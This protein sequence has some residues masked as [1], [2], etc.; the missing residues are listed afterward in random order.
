MNFPTPAD[1]KAPAGHPEIAAGE[2]HVWRARLDETDTAALGTLLSPTEWIRAQ[3]FHFQSDRQHFIAGR[4]LLRTILGRYLDQAPQELRFTQGPHGKPELDGVGSSLRF[5]LS[6][7]DDLML[8]AVTHARAVGVDLELMREDVPFQTLAD[9]YFEPEDAWHLRLLPPAQR[10][11]KFYDL[12]TRTEAR[13]KADGAGL[14]RGLKILEPD[15]W[16]LLK[17]TPAD[18]YAAALAVEGGDFQV[19]CWSWPK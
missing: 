4:G 11:W 17:L 13:L 19:E 16:S 7:S 3:R 1:W 2:V 6:H 12:W 9:Y 18:G 10:A 15:R 14:G 5:N 8:L